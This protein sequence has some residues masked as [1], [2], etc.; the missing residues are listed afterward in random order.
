MKR[1]E[2]IPIR[3]GI[4][5]SLADF[6]AGRCYGPF[7]SAREAVASMQAQLRKRASSKRRSPS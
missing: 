2:L 1:A 7:N 3:R 5:E 4:A 6:K